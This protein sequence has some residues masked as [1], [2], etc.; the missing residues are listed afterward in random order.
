MKRRKTGKQD[1]KE[2]RRKAASKTPS[3]KLD[4]EDGGISRFHQMEKIQCANSAGK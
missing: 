1:N 2:Q 4:G 3:K